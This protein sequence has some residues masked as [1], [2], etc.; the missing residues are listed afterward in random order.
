VLRTLV[1]AILFLGSGAVASAVPQKV[2]ATVENGAAVA[3]QT[4]PATR[5]GEQRVATYPRHIAKNHPAGLGDLRPLAEQGNA[6]AQYKLGL[7]YSR[8]QGVAQNYVAAYMWL[9]LANA[10]ATGDLG[11]DAI[12]ARFEVSSLMP[13]EQIAEARRQAIEWQKKR[14]PDMPTPGKEDLIATFAK[15]E[16]CSDAGHLEKGAMEKIIVP[17]VEY[18][19]RL[20]FTESDIDE[21]GASIL[22]RKKNTVT[23]FGWGCESAFNTLSALPLPGRSTR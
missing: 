14:T 12:K 21:M 4:T 5:V 16:A 6:E 9:H 10:G 11:E 22:T 8:G 15:V 23:V 18:Y 19:A 3:R 20:F 2:P 13:P 1:V 7:L 17:R